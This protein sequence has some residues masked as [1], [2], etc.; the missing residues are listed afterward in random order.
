MV[1]EGFK[2]LKKCIQIAEDASL[3]KEKKVEKYGEALKTFEESFFSFVKNILAKD[4]GVIG[5]VVMWF[6]QFF[7]FSR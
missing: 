2:L 6:T 7:D 1:S 5:E 4:S 3:E